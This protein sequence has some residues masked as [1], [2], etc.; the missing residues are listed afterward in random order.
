MINWSAHTIQ[1]FADISILKPYM[2]YSTVNSE[3]QKYPFLGEWAGKS[4]EKHTAVAHEESNNARDA[5]FSSFN[6][7]F[8]PQKVMKQSR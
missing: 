8:I 5:F 4:T 7:L 3:R 1:F 6:L 2:L